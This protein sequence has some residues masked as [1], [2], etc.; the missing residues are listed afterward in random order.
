MLIHY[1]DRG[2]Q[3]ASKAFRELLKYNELIAQSMSRKGNCWDNAVAKSF[4]KSLKVELV[5][6]NEFK[7][8]DEAKAKVFEWV[9]IWYTKLRLYQTLGYKTPHEMEQ[10]FYQLIMQHSPLK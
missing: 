6:Y 1:S 10:E 8:I 4:F 3:Y 9:E 7:T 5:Y 2:I